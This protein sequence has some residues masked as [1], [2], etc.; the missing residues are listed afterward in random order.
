MFYGNTGVVLVA[1]NLLEVNLSEAFA[2]CFFFCFCFCFVFVFCMGREKM[3]GA[4][5]KMDPKRETGRSL[6]LCSLH[7]V[8]VS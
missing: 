4:M 2:I 6:I 7:K 8:A 3:D 1:L 5:Q